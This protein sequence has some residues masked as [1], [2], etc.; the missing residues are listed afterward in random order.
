MGFREQSFEM[1]ELAMGFEATGGRDAAL[2]R[3]TKLRDRINK[4]EMTFEALIQRWSESDPLARQKASL[5]LTLG[6]VRAISQESFGGPAFFDFATSGQAGDICEIMESA[7]AA[8]IFQMEKNLPAQ[9]VQAFESWDIQEAMR[10][11]LQN[12][13]R[14]NRLGRAHRDLITESRLSD[15]GLTEYMLDPS[16]LFRDRLEN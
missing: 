8:H 13:Q 3:I 7:T 15:G 5:T 2:E 9:S 6:Q 16:W 14:N 1:L 4:G 11:H 12:K 10:A